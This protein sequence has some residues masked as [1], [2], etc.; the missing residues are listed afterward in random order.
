M[1]Y[2]KSWIV[3]FIGMLLTGC[4]GSRPGSEKPRDVS[5]FAASGDE[6]SYV[7]RQGDQIRIR[8]QEYPEFDTTAVV[9]EA[10]TISVHLVGELPV[11][12]LTK[13]QF[14]KDFVSKL[15]LYVKKEAAVT[16]SIINRE[17]LNVTVLGSV[18]RQGVYPAPLDGS[19]L[20]ILATAGGPVTDSD[21]RHVKIFRNRDYSRPIEADL[22]LTLNKPEVG[23][24]LPTVGGGDIV[25]IPKEENFVSQMGNYLR[26][27]FFLFSLLNFFK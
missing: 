17:S 20:E 5:Q 11:A 13:A 27:A 23:E 10:G 4:A 9:S 6:N 19:L 15:S 21:L 26:D 18:A 3:L 14:T 16:I 12:G 22:T 8:V 24:K 7:I 1:K 25:F 2:L